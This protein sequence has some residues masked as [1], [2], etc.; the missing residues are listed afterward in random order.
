MMAFIQLSLLQCLFLPR[1]KGALAHLK[2]K[3]AV[4]RYVAPYHKGCPFR[5]VVTRARL[6]ACQTPV[7]ASK[8][9]IVAA[10]RCP[11][12]LLSQSSKRQAE[13]CMFSIPN[14]PLLRRIG[15][16][17]QTAQRRVSRRLPVLWNLGSSSRSTG[18][19]KTMAG[20]QSRGLYRILSLPMIA[21]LVGVPRNTSTHLGRALARRDMS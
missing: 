16:E 21:E 13:H 14:L 19:V 5:P 7:S 12:S 11:W 9:V 1:Q 6:L 2:K 20:G 18:A 10:I 3:K 8:S 15:L 17:R 4:R